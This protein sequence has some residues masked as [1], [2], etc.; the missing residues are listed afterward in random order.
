M[1]VRVPIR[2]RQA[3]RFVWQVTERERVLQRV[4]PRR[5]RFQLCFFS[6]H[7]YFAYLYCSIHSLKAALADTQYSIIVFS[8][9]DQPLSQPQIEALK[10]LAP[11]CRV[12][13]WPKSMGWG[14]EQ[15]GNIWRAYAL[16]ADDIADDDFV[17]R[18]DSDVFFFND[19]IFR[20]VE[21]SE[22]DLIGDGHFVDFA[23]CQGGAYFVRARAVRRIVDFLAHND[24]AGV[25]NAAGINVEDVA[26]HHFARTLGLRVWLTWFMMFPDE[27]RN[28]GGLTPWQRWKFSCLHFVMKNKAAMIEAYRREVLVPDEQV[29]FT[30]EIGTT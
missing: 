3:P 22:A 9:T 23:Y 26:I 10:S 19:R 17:V 12:L 14:A 20:A 18:V 29:R 15:I 24:L 4:P 30:H 28:A 8:D 1:K 6:C 5:A 2:V 11:G 7:S 27:L 13:P 25:L 21:R 16:A